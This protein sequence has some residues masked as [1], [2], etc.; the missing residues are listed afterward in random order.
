M[1]LATAYAVALLPPALNAADFQIACKVPAYA[2]GLW[3]DGQDPTR[4]DRYSATQARERLSKLS[5]YTNAIRLYGAQ[6][7][8]EAACIA[9]NEFGMKVVL[10][11]WIGRNYE[12]NEQE[13]AAA[14]AVVSTW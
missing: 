13:I 11:A 2:T 3:V 12:T 1:T 4:G 7:D 10:G 5:Q 14:I 6:V 8:A 9:K